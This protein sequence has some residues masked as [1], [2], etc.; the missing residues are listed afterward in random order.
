MAE[1]TEL[2]KQIARVWARSVGTTDS[3]WSVYQTLTDIADSLQ[4]T[5]RDA[6][7]DMVRTAAYVAM[8][9]TI[10]RIREAA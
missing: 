4:A 2:E 1:M 8:D 10:T 6:D 9:H 7:A 5:W 3:W